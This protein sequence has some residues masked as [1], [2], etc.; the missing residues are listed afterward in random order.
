ITVKLTRSLPE[1]P[2]IPAGGL[3]TTFPDPP[4]STSPLRFALLQTWLQSCDRD[5]PDCKH[6]TTTPQENLP[7]RLLELS[8][9]DSLKL[10]SGQEVSSPRYIA[11]L[12]HRWGDSDKTPSYRTTN[13]NIH[14]R[15]EGSNFHVSDLPLTFQDAIKVSRGLSIYYLW[16]DSL[17]IIQDC[18]EDWAK[19]S[20]RME[21][22]YAGAYCTIA[23]T[24]ATNSQEGFLGQDIDSKHLYVYNNDNPSQRAYVRVETANF[25]QEVDGAQLNQRGWVLQ[26]RLL[27]RRTI[28]FGSSEMYFEC[29]YGRYGEDLN[30]MKRYETPN[31][32]F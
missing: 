25:D 16:I 8:K 31:P 17:C 11:T 3:Q 10:V 12:S 28:H 19:E 21:D 23:A 24:S 29:G 18:K 13:N 15:E 6:T 5:H 4:L 9:P 26:E 32:V 14:S 30:Q 27:S 20:R 22:V 7:I 1:F 2:S